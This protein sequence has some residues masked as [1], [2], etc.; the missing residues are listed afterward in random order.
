MDVMFYNAKSFNQSLAGWNFKD[1]SSNGFFGISN[2]LDSCGMD[3]NN[4][5]KTLSGWAAN[6]ELQ[7]PYLALGAANLTY[8]SAFAKAAHDSL[9]NIKEWVI[10][11]DA[12][13]HCSVILPVNFLSFN[14]TKQGNAALLN[15]SVANEINNKG[16][17]LEKSTNGVNF[18]SIAFVAG[19]G[20]SKQTT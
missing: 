1:I 20:P 6:A 11:G 9:I 17:Y 10:I 13:G 12:M 14:V 5:S 3:C 16:Y 7:T 19:K 2:M 18:N 4:Y 15:W 8:D